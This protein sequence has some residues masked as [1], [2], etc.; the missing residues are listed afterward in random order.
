MFKIKTMINI[1]IL[2]LA[3]IICSSF[4]LLAVTIIPFLLLNLK[5][6]PLVKLFIKETRK[7]K[8]RLQSMIEFYALQKAGAF[9]GIII[10]LI[11]FLILEYKI[12]P[13]YA[14]YSF[15]I[16]GWIV[17]FFSCWRTNQRISLIVENCLTHFGRV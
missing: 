4:Y 6:F 11:L 16:T 12:L 3:L 10:Y 8:S 5:D 2:Y 13:V 17:L 15:L 14:H 7:G 9:A 1:V